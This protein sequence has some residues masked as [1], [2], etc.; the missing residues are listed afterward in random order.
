MTDVISKIISTSLVAGGMYLSAGQYPKLMQHTKATVVRFEVS[1]IARF[2][3]IDSIDTKPPTSES[4]SAY[5]RKHVSTTDQRDAAQDLWGHPYQIRLEGDKIL[6][7]SYGP[8]GLPETADDIKAF[9]VL[10]G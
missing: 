1:Q 2:V 10:Y 4:F 6:V 8:D 9:A 3:S 7:F 5:I